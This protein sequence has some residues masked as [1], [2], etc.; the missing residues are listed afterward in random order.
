MCTHVERM[1]A[2][3]EPPRRSICLPRKMGKFPY[4]LLITRFSLLQAGG[5]AKAEDGWRGH[6]R[7][8]PQSHTS[9]DRYSQQVP[10]LPVD[11]VPISITPIGTPEDSRIPS[12]GAAAAAAAASAHTRAAQY[13]QHARA[14]QLANKGNNAVNVPGSI[15]AVP[16]QHKTPRILCMT[17][18]TATAMTEWG[19]N[20]HERYACAARALLLLTACIETLLLFLSIYNWDLV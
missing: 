14:S 12:F 8:A 20:D 10:S 11:D 15:G 5:V 7:P 3:C 18:C 2:C 6:P 17:T 1:T 19:W 13:R 4:Q 9:V 16:H